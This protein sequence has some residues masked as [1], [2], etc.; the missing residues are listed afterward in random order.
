MTEG[1][2]SSVAGLTRTQRKRANRIATIERTA[3]K[4]FAEKG[5]E[6]TSFDDIAELLELRGSSLF[7]YFAS[8]N[9]LFLR[10]LHN[11]AEQVFE[12]LREVRA[13]GGSPDVVWDALVREQ[14]LIQVR[15]FPEFSPLFFQSSSSS[16]ELRGEVLRLRREHALIFEEVAAQ[17][18]ELHGTTPAA[19]RVHLGIAFGAM[20]FL[21]EWYNPDGALKADE[22]ADLMARELALGTAD[23]RTAT[24]TV[25]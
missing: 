6:R 14:V 3:A 7:H 2:A 23:S 11:S 20:A 5:V 25:S 8:K 17:W 10:I 22:L 19:N 24:E 18:S 4:V 13:L 21:S 9:E 15:D 16:E 1:T 12:R